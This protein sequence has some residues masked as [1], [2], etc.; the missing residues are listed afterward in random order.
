MAVTVAASV[1]AGIA[2]SAWDVEATADADTTATVTHNFGTTLVFAWLVPLAVVYYTSQWI[3]S[4]ITANT[5]VLT[6]G[7]GG[8]SGA[9]G[10]QVR[11]Y[12]LPYA[13]GRLVPGS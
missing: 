9:V 4:S 3:I 2:R 13:F 5:V 6:K 12:V 11:C 8:G 10:N 1:V 7:I